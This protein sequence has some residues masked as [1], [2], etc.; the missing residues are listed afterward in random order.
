MSRSLRSRVLGALSW[1]AGA[2]A[3]GQII[4]WGITLYVI[5]L[6][7][8][9][10]YGIMALAMVFIGITV[11]LSELG[12]GAALIQTPTLE[13]RLIRQ[14]Y[15]FALLVSVGFFLAITAAAGPV[16]AFFDSPGLASVLPVLAFGLVLT[17]VSICPKAILLRDLNLRLTSLTEVGGAIGG[18]LLTLYLAHS[19]YGVWSLVWGHLLTLALAATVLLAVAG[20]P[21]LPSFDLRGVGQSLTFGVWVTLDRLMWMLWSQADALIIGKV[22]GEVRLGSYAVAKEIAQIPQT[23]IQGTINAV[24]FPAYAEAQR[25]E[26]AA[27]RY[28]QKY[29]RLSAMVAFPVFWGIGATAPVFVPLLLGDP[30]EAAILPMQIIAFAMP[31]RVAQAAVSPYLQAVGEARRATGNMVIGLVLM[32]TAVLIGSRWGLPGVSLGWAVAAVLIL[33]V[34]LWRTRPIAGVAPLI[35]LMQLARVALPALVMLLAVFAASAL[36]DEASVARL[37]FMIAAG[38]FAYPLA[39][40]ALCRPEAREVVAMFKPRR[41]V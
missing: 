2:K 41:N 27:A 17:A 8:P 28:L 38:F 26:G 13:T 37:A 29:I 36:S 35:L 23:K 12:L 5:R 16:A 25:T 1:A 32:T 7:T 34:V 39:S 31:A 14:V 19:G 33:L 9:Q 24:A 20:T 15:G 22:L 30:W 3:L 6:L 21:K 10:D 4:S 11:P 40:W 18:G